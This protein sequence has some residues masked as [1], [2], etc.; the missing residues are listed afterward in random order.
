MQRKR[1]FVISPI[2]DEGS[3]IRQHADDVYEYIIKPAMEACEINAIRSD[4][5]PEPGNISEQMFREILNDDLC[6][7]VLTGNNPNV[8][9]E[10]AIAHAA[11][12]PVVILLEKGQVLPFDVSQLRCVYYDLKP[13][14]LF[15]K[16]Y[17]DQVVDHI[18]NLETSGWK[19]TTPFGDVSLAV[20]DQPFKFVDRSM[21]YGNPDTWL[22]HLQ[23]TEHVFE[24]MG[25]SLGSW[26]RTREFSQVLKEKAAAGCQARILLMHKDNPTLRHLINDAIPEA[27]YSSVI[28]EI[29]EV[30]SYFSDIA[31]QEPNVEIRQML[32][33]CPHC[34]LTR[35]DQRAMFIPYLYSERSHYSPLW[36]VPQ[37]SPLYA[38][39]A[40]EFES[41]WKA[42]APEADLSS[43]QVPAP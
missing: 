33:G 19:G 34:Q 11:V 10:L 20:K 27:R 24:T 42:N 22:Q 4:Q 23:S 26:R 8:Y 40:Q 5:L 14:P 25:I 35:F 18:R 43:R 28:N 41:L 32:R 36:E 15:E 38:V 1:C 29:D 30:F 12:R 6:V 39:M 16:V 21:N 31:K 13:K 9:Y 7:A 2:G 37:G 3:E 17:V